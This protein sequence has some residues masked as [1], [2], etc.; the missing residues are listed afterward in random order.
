VI[1]GLHGFVHHNSAS[2]WQAVANAPGQ[3]P[4][5]FDQYP[6]PT[7]MISDPGLG[8]DIALSA[9]PRSTGSILKPT[10]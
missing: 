8:G 7:H 9:T 4:I 3:L 6:Q 5:Q 2:S 10:S 1:A